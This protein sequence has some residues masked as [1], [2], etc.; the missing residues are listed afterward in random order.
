MERAG[1]VIVQ[2][3]VVHHQHK[4]TVEH[5]LRFVVI[6]LSYS[7]VNSREINW[8]FN[9][10]QIIRNFGGVDRMAEGP[11]VLLLFDFSNYA[12]KLILK[13]TFLPSC[14]FPSSSRCDKI[15]HRP[16]GLFNPRDRECSSGWKISARHP[17]GIR[18]KSLGKWIVN[19]S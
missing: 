5:F 18:S 13:N 2:F 6:V 19:D 12:E 8:I 3:T 16:T 10:I 7:F 4:V 17:F 9:Y 14:L 11:S 15:S 1:V